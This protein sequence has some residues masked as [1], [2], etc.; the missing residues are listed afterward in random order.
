MF[1]FSLTA[2]LTKID[3][4]ICE[5]CTYTKLIIYKFLLNIVLS[6]FLN[7]TVQLRMSKGVVLEKIYNVSWQMKIF[8]NNWT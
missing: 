1:G 4:N 8:E 2:H 5:T 7:K 6:I 3:T